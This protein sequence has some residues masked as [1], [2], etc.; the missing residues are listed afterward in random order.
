MRYSCLFAP[1]CIQRITFLKFSSPTMRE[2]TIS[3]ILKK[4][5]NPSQCS[6]YQPVSL[7]NTDVK[8]LAK[9][10]GPTSWGAH[11]LLNFIRPARLHEELVLFF[12][13]RSLLKRPLIGWS[14]TNFFT[15]KENLGLAIILD[16]NSKECTGSLYADDLLL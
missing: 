3:L 1:H 13:Y 6:S 12:W 8:I 11:A 7:L 10:F 5:K 14:G 2:V 9:L 15:L 16:Q 4:D